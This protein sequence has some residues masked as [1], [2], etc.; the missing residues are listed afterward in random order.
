MNTWRT[1]V[2][3]NMLSDVKLYFES[4]TPQHSAK[5][6]EKDHGRIEQR[7]Y[8]LETGIDRSSGAARKHW[9]IESQLH[10]QL[11][12]TFGEDSS[13][14]RK[15]NSPLK[16]NILREQ[17]LFLLDRADLGKRVSLRR[18]ISRAAMDDHTLHLVR[19]AAK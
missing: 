11:D 5:R 1:Q 6:I 3:G 4:E 7:E 15:D 18:K 9:S 16:L 19:F 12:V 14:A 2:S 8:C 13:R 10:W 17:A